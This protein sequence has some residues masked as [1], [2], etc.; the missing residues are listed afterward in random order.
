MHPSSRCVRAKSLQSCP[1]LCDPMDCS[2]P[3]LLCPRDSPGKNTG[4]GGHSLLQWIFPDPRLRCRQ[5]PGGGSMSLASQGSGLR[6]IQPGERLWTFQFLVCCARSLQP[7]SI[8]CLRPSAAAS[9]SERVRELA[10]GGGRS[11]GMGSSP[12]LALGADLASECSPPPLSPSKI[13][14]GRGSCRVI[15]RAEEEV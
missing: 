13:P 14:G 12:H 6:N 9:P 7:L 11:R 10:G 5:R 3:R 4:V 8:N 15:G 1:T 2:P